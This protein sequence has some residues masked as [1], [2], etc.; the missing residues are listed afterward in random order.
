[1]LFLPRLIIKIFSSKKSYYKKNH[2]YGIQ[3]ITKLA[4]NKYFWSSL[5][6]WIWY[7]QKFYVRRICKLGCFW[8]SKNTIPFFSIGFDISIVIKI[9]SWLFN[10]KH[11]WALYLS[12]DFPKDF[13]LYWTLYL[14]VHSCSK[15]NHASHD[16]I[17]L[18]NKEKEWIIV[19][20]FR[21]K[22]KI[23]EL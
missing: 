18:D 21:I 17:S 10:M 14:V 7:W 5:S 8:L 22:I 12:S 9:S 16:I 23:K 3:S 11:H 4:K 1:V 20:S 19:S 6:S 15:I 2:E 13:L